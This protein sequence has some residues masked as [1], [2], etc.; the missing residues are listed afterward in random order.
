MHYNYDVYQGQIIVNSG[1]I[2]VPS[3]KKAIKEIWKKVVLSTP[4]Q[5]FH[6]VSFYINGKL[7]FKGGEFF[8]PAVAKRLQDH[9]EH[10]WRT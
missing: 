3:E 6:N 8:V 10:P 4:Q 1:V 2:A 9:P 7:I 5:K